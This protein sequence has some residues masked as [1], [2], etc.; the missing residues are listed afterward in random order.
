MKEQTNFTPGMR[1]IRVENINPDSLTPLKYG[2]H[3][4]STARH[5]LIDMVENEKHI[6]T[7]F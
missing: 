2:Y 6:F 7:S 4:Q 1:T 5:Q 3:G